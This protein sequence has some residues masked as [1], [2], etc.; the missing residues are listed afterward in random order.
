M[1]YLTERTMNVCSVGVCIFILKM[2]IKTTPLL[3]N[4][5]KRLD[6]DTYSDRVIY[7]WNKLILR[8]FMM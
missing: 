2:R 8:S 3:K 1:Y 6:C 5:L 4:Y 7:I